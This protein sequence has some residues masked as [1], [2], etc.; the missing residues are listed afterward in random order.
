VKKQFREAVSYIRVS[1]G[2][3]YFALFFFL[4]FVFF[5]FYFSKNLGFIDDFLK[6]LID[7]VRGLSLIEMILFILQNN[8]QASLYGLVFGAFFAI[9]PLLNIVV[10]GVVVGYVLAK[11]GELTGLYEIWSCLQFLY[12]LVWV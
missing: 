2:Y 7:R 12:R 5:G 10:N 1:R 8:I 11:V 6:E 4:L 9:F 3:I